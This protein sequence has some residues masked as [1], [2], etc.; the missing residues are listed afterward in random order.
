MS[1]ISVKVAFVRTRD[2]STDCHPSSKTSGRAHAPNGPD[3]LRQLLVCPWN[4]SS[5]GPAAV[6]YAEQDGL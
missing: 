2:S 5:G 4:S 1:N 6:S 3:P